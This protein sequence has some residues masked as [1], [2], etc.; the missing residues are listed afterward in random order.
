[1]FEFICHRLT[2]HVTQIVDPTEVSCFLVT[3]SEKA[4]LIDTAVGF[5]GL[6]DTVRGLTS[7]P[8]TVILTHAHGDHAGGAG[9]FEEVYLHPADAPLRKIHGLEKR[10]GYAGAMLGPEA[11]LTEELFVPETDAEFKELFD[12][13]KFSLGG[14][15]LRII[16]VPGHTKGCCCV[17]LEEE[18]SIL[19]G[20]ACNGN[21]LVMDEASTCISEYQRSLEYLKTFEDAYDTVYYSHGPA[22]GP[23]ECLEDNLILCDRILSGTDDAV[24]CEFMGRQ[25]IRAARIQGR[26]ERVDGRSGNIVYSELTRR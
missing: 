16:H 7:L 19:Y 4:L 1:M 15:T 10:M 8:V 12:G 21:T 2:E 3:G 13:Q 22:V 18:R 23:R 5:R 26:F 9:E 6:A 25:A 24:P 20:D 14:L 11:G 17:L